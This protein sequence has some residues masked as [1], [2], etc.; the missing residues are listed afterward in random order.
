MRDERWVDKNPGEDQRNAD[1]S[2][3][4]CTESFSKLHSRTRPTRT[5]PIRP[6]W[7]ADDPMDPSGSAL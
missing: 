4:P 6:G 7:V 2:F 5:G 1:E 3:L